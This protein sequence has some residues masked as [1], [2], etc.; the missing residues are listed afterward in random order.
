VQAEVDDAAMPHFAET[1]AV[2][3]GVNVRLF[4]SVDAAEQWLWE[5]C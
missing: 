1:L 4:Q 5:E 2:N 3:R